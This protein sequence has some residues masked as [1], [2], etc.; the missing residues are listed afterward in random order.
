MKKVKPKSIKN[1]RHCS[2][3][4]SAYQLPMLWLDQPLH[5]WFKDVL[6]PNHQEILQDKGLLLIEL[7]LLL[8]LKVEP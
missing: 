3:W 8:Q 7:L 5:L 4:V 6:Q 2:L 1:D